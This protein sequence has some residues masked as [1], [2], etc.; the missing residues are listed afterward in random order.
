MP[1]ACMSSIKVKIKLKRVEQS[2]L[3]ISVMD[4]CMSCQLPYFVGFLRTPYS[5]CFL[6]EE[7]WTQDCRLLG[8]FDSSGFSDPMQTP[9]LWREF[10]LTT[11]FS[12]S[13][14]DQRPSSAPLRAEVSEVLTRR[15]QLPVTPSLSAGRWLARYVSVFHCSIWVR[16]VI[17]RRHS[18]RVSSCWLK[19]IIGFWG[20][21]QNL[22]HGANC[23]PSTTVQV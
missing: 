2:W 11:M 10:P 1:Q 18:L 4:N 13:S 12:V 5:L 7:I 22:S 15:Q 3:F 6:Q 8:S 17:C 20:K 23:W 16:F 21:S 9:K 14:A 19:K